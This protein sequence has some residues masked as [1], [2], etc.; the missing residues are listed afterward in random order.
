MKKPTHISEKKLLKNM[1][2]E[3]KKITERIMNLALENIFTEAYAKLDK[4]SRER[5]E[6]VFKTGTDRQKTLAV[7]KYV[8]DFD[9]TYIKEVE[10][11]SKKLKDRLGK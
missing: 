10:R 3:F 7:R 8:S 5:M 9:Q 4:E 6:A 11:I 2:P 1:P